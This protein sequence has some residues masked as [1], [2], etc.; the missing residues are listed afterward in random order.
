M[1]ATTVLRA[2][3]VATDTQAYPQ[4]RGL[5]RRLKKRLERICEQWD[6][7]R[8]RARDRSAMARELGRRGGLKGGKARAAN[9]TPERLREI[10]R[11]GAVV[12]WHFPA[13]GGA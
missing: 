8:E 10:A 11:E 1:R 2:L 12:R 9:L 13:E 7:Q 6:A 5:V 3:L 4:R